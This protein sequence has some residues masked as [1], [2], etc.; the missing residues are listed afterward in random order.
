META[1]NDL[2]IVGAKKEMRALYCD[3]ANGS[4]ITWLLKLRNVYWLYI[5]CRYGEPFD[6]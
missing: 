6:Q 1:M 2:P 4:Q 5:T 3:V